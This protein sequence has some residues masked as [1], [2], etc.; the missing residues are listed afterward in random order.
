MDSPRTEALQTDTP[1]DALAPDAALR[2]LL[3]GQSAAL[4]AINGARPALAKAANQ[5][6]KSLRDGH[7]LV[8]AGAGSSGLMAMA[9]ALELPGT[10]GIP[11]AQV[12]IFMAGGL[13]G[14]ATMPGDTEDD[15]TQGA[16]DAADLRPGDTAIVVSAS[17]TTPYACAF[18]RAA[19]DAGATVIGMANVPESQLLGLVHLPIC[20]PTP[21]EQL[22]GSTRLGAGTAQKAALNMISTLAGVL[23]GHV[24]AGQMV[25]LRADNA[26]LRARARRMVAQ[27]AAVHEDRAAKA[28]DAAGGAVKPAILL[29]AGAPDIGAAQD[30]LARAEGRLAPALGSLTQ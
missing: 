4:A 15:D 14:L 25:N 20:L 19:A 30:M 24:H 22:A 2:R 16:R 7:R 17:G 21:P 23:L 8:Y 3:D 28:L 11:E 1:L 9:D 10:F 5:V 12:G 18:A 29:A 27:I 6:A 13:P 26:K